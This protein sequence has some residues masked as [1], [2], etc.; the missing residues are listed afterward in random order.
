MSRPDPPAVAA[1]VGTG[2][3]VAYAVVGALQVLV[4]NPLAAVPRLS[5]P[6]IHS[7]LDRV[8]QSFSPAPVIAWAVLGVGAAVV[9]AVSTI[10][11]S[12]L[13]LSQVVLAQAL[14]LVGGAPSLLLVS[15]APGMQLADGFGISGYD[16]SPWA[17][18]LYLTSL[19]AMA[20]AIAAAGPAITASRARPSECGRVL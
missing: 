19:L 3:V 20:A 6:E 11:R 8:G 7:E 2:L 17:R 13:T 1:S 14:V 4:W 9:V 15:F 18:P 12:R 10:R 5:L 16:H